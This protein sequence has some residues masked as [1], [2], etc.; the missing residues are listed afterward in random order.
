MC[1]GNMLEKRSF[2]ALDGECLRLA[3]ASGA[4]LRV[5]E[6]TRNGVLLGTIKSVIG[7][8]ITPEYTLRTLGEAKG[9]WKARA[10][11]PFAEKGGVC[12]ASAFA[13]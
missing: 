7:P 6:R 5:F 2:C 12:A 1:A 3:G 4:A 11:P 13:F 10:E 9:G 8:G